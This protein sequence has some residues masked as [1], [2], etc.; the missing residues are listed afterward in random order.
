MLR[1]SKQ[2]AGADGE[3]LSS[4]L[5]LR[6]DSDIESE[7][8]ANHRSIVSETQHEFELRAMSFAVLAHAHF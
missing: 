4:D 1:K 6:S 7:F 3:S 2:P 5:E 8:S